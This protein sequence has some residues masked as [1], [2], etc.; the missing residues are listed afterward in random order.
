MLPKCERPGEDEAADVPEGYI[1]L[2][3]PR[4]PTLTAQRRGGGI[5]LLQL[6]AE[7]RART[8]FFHFRK[9]SA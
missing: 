6:F 3:L 4:K 7:L 5:A 2:S 1:L 9:F 8:I